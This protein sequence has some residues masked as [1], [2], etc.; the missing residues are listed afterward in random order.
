MNSN[1]PQIKTLIQN[2]KSYISNTKFQDEIYKWELIK[3]YKGRP[4]TDALDF[5]AEY[6]AIKFGNLLYQLAG[7]VG[8]H[9]CKENP[10]EFRQLF[11]YLFDE[12]IPLNKRVSYFNVESLKL[13]RSLGETL[14]HHQDERSISTYLTLHNPEK[15]TFYK[16]TFYKEFCK[17]MGAVPAEKN[18]K[19]GHYLELV[20]QFIE[21]YIVPDTELT[22][23]VKSYIPQYYDG[24]NNL[25]L[26][27]DILY[28]MLNKAEEDS[29]CW[30]FQGNLKIYNVVGALNDNVLKTWSVKTHK[31]AIQPGDK[32]ILWVS[33][34]KAGCYALAE[35]TSDVFE[36]KDDESEMRYYVAARTNEMGSRVSIK[37][38]HNLANNP[39][40]K[41]QIQG[42]EELSALKAG[43]QGTNFKATKIEY[44]IFLKLA[45]KNV[46]N[47]KYWLYAPGEKAE[48]WDE[49][50]QSG[51]MALG[52]DQLE[53]L[54]GYSSKEEIVKRLQAFEN[55]DGSKKNDAT[56]NDEFFSTMKIGDV[57]IVKKGRGE[58]L[59]YGYVT[60]DYYYDMN[61]EYFKHCRKM[62][63]ILEGNW[64]IDGNLALK[65]LTDITVYPSDYPEY[66]KYYE[67]LLGAMNVSLSKKNYKEDFAKWLSKASHIE[68][69]AK[70]SYLRGIEILN[71]KVKYNIYEVD[72][73]QTL[74]ELYN[75]LIKEQKNKNGIYFHEAA[76]SYGNNGFY[77]A[78]IKTYK[79]FLLDHNKRQNKTNFAMALN[80]IL[81]GPPGTGKTFTL[82]KDYFPEYTTRETSITSDQH[83]E[84]VVR[85]LT[86]WQ[87]IA[88]AVNE[89]GKCKVVDIAKNEWVLKKAKL[90]NSNSVRPTIWG[91]LQSHTVDSCEFVNVRSKQQPYIFNKSE[92]SYWTLVEEELKESYPEI[93]EIIDSV[94]N[95]KPNPDKEIKRFV[96]TTFHQSYAYEDFIEGIK[97]ILQE[98]EADGELNY[99][100]EDGVFKELCKR[101]ELDPKNRYA[102]F[103]DEIN[104][105]NVS[106]VFGELITLIE[107]DKRKGAKNALSAILP[108]SKKSFSVPNNV[109]IY[110]TMNTADRSIEALDTALRRRFSF[111]EMIPNPD[112]LKDKIVLEIKLKDLLKKINERIEALIDR[113]HTIGHAYLIDVENEA[114][115]RRAF[116]D[117]IIPL[118][119]EYFFGDYGKIGLVLGSAFVDKGTI[120]EKI[121]SDFEYEGREG[122]IQTT[123]QLKNFDQID[124]KAA[125]AALVK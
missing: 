108:Y 96:F 19:Y 27:Q 38:T 37:I 103:I 70:S 59:G 69:S 28:C 120:D 95:F 44:D 8:N 90:S 34:N 119:Q 113:D 115:L 56:A 46:T 116:K 84:S 109:D 33:G 31:D 83:F 51:I 13:Y 42:I 10:E 63:W 121:F 92:D 77:S 105:A 14:G 29:N 3:K 81:Y 72:N 114:D 123:Y 98:E 78:S 118:L 17:L 35:V 60:S 102:I 45:E 4:D 50:Y 48:L 125:L 23:T 18:E 101:A 71:E 54:N 89:L 106:A 88:I 58:L 117:K 22:D 24:K 104:R 9:I 86:W 41:D 91:Q 99:R 47:R 85:E 21:N 75:D 76:P 122:L 53:D 107:G 87:V 26:A 65:T 55:T 43:S 112:L 94:K 20:N 2:Y 67:Q 36:A 110:G 74:D 7:A 40:L 80:Q 15:Y 93:F 16:S 12:T 97:P 52:W 25:L 64:K 66:T 82:K 62:N 6:K 30:I 1:N 11:V 39:I 111:V 61:R 49:F 57:V 100:I 73:L 68:T 124:F 79:D 5:A 32:V